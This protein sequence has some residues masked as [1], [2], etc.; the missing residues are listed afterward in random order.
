VRRILSILFVL[1]FLFN[2]WGYYPVYLFQQYQIRSEVKGFLG[3]SP[4]MADFVFTFN[5]Q[6]LHELRWI[7]ENEFELNGSY[8]DILKQH[9]NPNGTITFYCY[10]DSKEKKL[11]DHLDNHLSR[12]MDDRATNQNNGKKTFKNP[13][14]D[15]S[16]PKTN[17][18]FKI[19]YVLISFVDISHKFSEPYLKTED[20]P[21]RYM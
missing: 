3:E 6:Q 16:P 9:Q 2:I 20:P 13:I 4:K 21:P 15:L 7:K 1:V 5:L 11:V 17:L 10:L 18:S 8:Y 12:N 14:K 19:C